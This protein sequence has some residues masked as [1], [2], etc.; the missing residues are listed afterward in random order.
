MLVHKE[1][2]DWAAM[3]ADYAAGK[4]S[5]AQMHALEEA[6]H[7]DPF[8]MDALE[9]YV[10]LGEKN[11]LHKASGI[12]AALPVKKED[13]SKGKIVPLF[14]R[15]WLKWSIAAAVILLVGIGIFTTPLAEYS[16]EDNDITTTIE[17][18]PTLADKVVVAPQE[19]EGK[20][21]IA[22]VKAFPEDVPQHIVRNA[23][24]LP[25][26]IKPNENNQPGKPVETVSPSSIHPADVARAGAEAPAPIFR[27]NGKVIEKDSEEPIDNAVIDLGGMQVVSDPI[28]RF[29][30]TTSK[31][32]MDIRV[33]ASGYRTAVITWHEGD[34]FLLVALQKLPPTAEEKIVG[35]IAKRKTDA[36]M[37]VVANDTADTA[38][39]VSWASFN[40]YFRSNMK[41]KGTSR[42]YKSVSLS[43]AVNDHGVP[44]DIEVSQS[45]GKEAEAEAIRLLK[46]GPKWRTKSGEQAMATIT[47]KY[48]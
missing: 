33:G 8:L 46:D 1:N 38:P 18:P 12:V 48:Q 3:L 16:G 36:T 23:D 21:S 34:N 32:P 11:H 6:A 24:N 2:T 45:A 5:A 31:L 7:H 20:D 39:L 37:V 26:G 14:S 10:L 29:F 40:D 35:D 47:I 43:F 44:V 4:L 17:L 13:K 27:S 42:I 30:V 15:G 19:N 25:R 22:A 9:G 28:G 41:A